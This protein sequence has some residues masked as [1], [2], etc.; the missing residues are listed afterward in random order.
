M[1][2]DSDTVTLVLGDRHGGEDITIRVGR[3]DLMNAT[4]GRNGTVTLTRG[5]GKAESL[6]SADESDV[7]V[8]K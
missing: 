3:E 2:V 8:V 1:E 7:E 5:V 6:A 4:V